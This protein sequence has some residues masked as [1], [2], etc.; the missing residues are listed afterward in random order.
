MKDIKKIFIFE[1]KTMLK[2]K[3]L[4]IS[5]LILLIIIFGVTFIPRFL[6]N[7][8]NPQEQIV[9][10][11]KEQ[12]EGFEKIAYILE[13]SNIK[14]EYLKVEIPFMYAKK[15]DNL[16][17]LKKD[18][19][20]KDINYGILF[21]SPTEYIIY[22]DGST[23]FVSDESSYLIE[24]GI[25]NYNKKL[26][27]RENNIDPNIVDA[28]NQ[29][30]LT[31]TTEEIGKSAEN[32]YFIAYIGVMLMYM[33]IILYGTSVSANV[34][35]EKSDRTM[36]LLITSTKPSS[37]II[38]KVFA[39]LA[40]SLIQI[41][42]MILVAYLGLKINKSVYPVELLN[43]IYS[44]VSITL[45]LIYLIYM[46]IGGL[47]YFFVYAA[48]GSLVS[49]VE[50]VNNAS[51]PIQIVIMAAFMIAM[52]GLSNPSGSLIKIASYIPLSS[53]VVMFVRYSMVEISLIDVL[54]SLGL[55]IITTIFIAYIS[56]KIYRRATLNYGN[57]MSLKTV[58][59]EL[60]ND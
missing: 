54:I 10:L 30:E 57:K 28:S 55:L 60:K 5:T 13:D 48:L 21:K 17:K 23:V 27:L 59:K 15:Y 3:S 24:E 46:I 39:S 41:I 8:L 9:E 25:K 47:M 1:L 49:R 4:I 44:N 43:M 58:L 33:I 50:E 56:I 2:Q 35:R 29:I 20:S 18:I 40:M 52:I 53:P 12:I 11:E 16:E 14:E 19:S 42:S 22:R 38:G 34:A 45:I 37:L 6:N 32:N 31:Y 26:Y 7:Q 36:E 51:S